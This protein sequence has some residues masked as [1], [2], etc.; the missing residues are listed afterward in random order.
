MGANAI[1]VD[2]FIAYN[3]SPAGGGVYNDMTGTMIIGG[4]SVSSNTASAG[5]GGGVYNNSNAKL[6]I[7]LTDISHNQAQGLYGDGGS[8]FG[9]GPLVIEDSNLTPIAATMVAAFLARMV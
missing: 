1:I 7:L 8:V 9:Y 4:G 3:T 5:P 6:T 2:P